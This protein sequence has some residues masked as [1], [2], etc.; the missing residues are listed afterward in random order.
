MSSYHYMTP[1]FLLVAFWLAIIMMDFAQATLFTLS[2]KSH[3]SVMK[4][5]V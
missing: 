5:K 4:F 1:K 3:S 2:G